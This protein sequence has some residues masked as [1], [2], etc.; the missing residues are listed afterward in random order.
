[1]CGGGGSTTNVT[2]TGLGDQQ[3]QDIMDG[4]DRI[5]AEVDDLSP[6]LDNVYNQNATTQ[7]LIRETR[8]DLAGR[9]ADANAK[10]DNI[11]TGL[12]Q[13]LVDPSTGQITNV[14]T[15]FGNLNESMTDQFGT[16]G[17]KIE[18]VNTNITD[19]R[20]EIGDLST[21]LG[22]L[23]S[24]VETGLTNTNQNITDLGTDMRT[25]FVDTRDAIN[26]GVGDLTTQIDDRFDTQNESLATNFQGTNDRLDTVQ[27]NVLGGQDVLRGLVE[28]QSTNLNRYYG[29]LAEGQ[30]LMQDSLG[31]IQTG[32]GSFRDT[33]DRNESLA[34]QQR[35]RLS[36][37][38][39]GGFN[40][41]REDIG[42]T[43]NSLGENQ[44]RMASQ[45]TGLGTQVGEVQANSENNFARVAR[46]IA[47]GFSDGT[48]QSQNERNDFISRLTAIRG[49][50]S[51]SNIKV[52][53][54][55]RQQFSDLATSFDE[56]GR[57]VSRSVDQQG[58]QL[59]RAIDAQ[60]NLLMAQFTP[61]GTRVA[62]QVL[63]IN[64]MM[65]ALD[66]VGYR[67][68]NVSSGTASPYYTT[69]R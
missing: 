39:S 6:K 5:F 47:T 51:D 30:S 9:T 64:R 48:I 62:Q 38:V 69:G 52:D 60:G 55:I 44:A 53:Q 20:T 54:T 35:S 23:T 56:Q 21:G 22:D 11:G 8:T 45:V 18:G 14:A 27:T 12:V 25:E 17:T 40:T 34:T 26:T 59:S 19:A 58:N 50:L 16:V 24:S 1:M 31:G 43:A 68:T 61:D 15:E 2:N 41:V 7:G 10:L 36:D 57:L 32:L 4:G 46:D 66:Q 63:D 3:Y 29:D 28:D 42:T 13:S 49:L 33:Y 65:Q 67:A 37:S